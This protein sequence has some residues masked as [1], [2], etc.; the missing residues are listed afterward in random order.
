MPPIQIDPAV[1]RFFRVVPTIS[2]EAW[3]NIALRVVVDAQTRGPLMRAAMKAPS[4][5]E[6]NK[7]RKRIADDVKPQFRELAAAG[8]IRLSKAMDLM[9]VTTFALQKRDKLGMDLVRQWFE[10]FEDVGVHL[11]DL[12]KDDA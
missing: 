7:I 9:Q 2:G 1:E 6:A 11:D 4:A 12:L 8:Y 5:A 3:K 10:P